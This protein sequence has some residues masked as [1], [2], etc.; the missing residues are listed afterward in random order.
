MCFYNS[1][2]KRALA[3]AKRYGKKTDIIEIWEDIIEEKKRN[4]EILDLT[5]GAYNIPAYASPFSAIVTD[6]EN[7][8][9]MRWGL[10]S[11]KT[12]SWATV[13]EKDKKNWYKNARSE[14]VF[15]T[16]PY[17]LSIN[18][19]RCL[20]PSTGFFEWHENPDKTKTPYHILLPNKEIFSIAGLWDEWVNPTNGEKIL[21]YVMLTTD[22]NDLLRE[23]HNSGANPFRMPLIIE[24]K[25]EMIWLNENL[26]KKNLD[27]LL[28]YKI[29]SDDMTAY[30]VDKSFRDT[31]NMYNP[32]IVRNVS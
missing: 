2:S 21:S 24:Q 22:A 27:S 8:Q 6:S 14:K 12:D 11:Y 1:Q 10:I 26:S 5:D 32:E 28:S 3:L 19:K 15:D 7:L 20:I 9:P 23:V 29:S 30:A 17:K 13:L 16:W 31:R 18:S 4:G 25:D